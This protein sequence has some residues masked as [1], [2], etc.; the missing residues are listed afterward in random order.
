MLYQQLQAAVQLASSPQGVGGSNP[1]M[2][3][4]LLQLTWEGQTT[5]T[6]R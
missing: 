5:S 6:R 3:T 2:L 4:V 1:C